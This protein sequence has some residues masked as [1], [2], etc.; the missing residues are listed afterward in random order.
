RCKNATPAQAIFSAVTGAH[1]M[2]RCTC[3]STGPGRAWCASRGSGFVELCLARSSF[4]TGAPAV[5]YRPA[6]AAVVEVAAVAA[7]AVAVA[8]AITTTRSALSSMIALAVATALALEHLVPGLDVPT[9]AVIT[10]RSTARP[11]KGFW[12]TREAVEEHFRAYLLNPSEKVLI[13]AGS[14]GTCK[15]TAA[16]HGVR[17]VRGTVYV[18]LSWE[19]KLSKQ[20]LVLVGM[21]SIERHTEISRPARQRAWCMLRPLFARGSEAKAGRSAKRRRDEPAPPAAPTP[22]EPAAP[23]SAGPLVGRPKRLKEAPPQSAPAQP[24]SARTGRRHAEPS[25]LVTAAAAAAGGNSG[26]GNEEGGS[27]AA[28][29]PPAAAVLEASFAAATAVMGAGA[30]IAGATPPLA[31]PILPPSLVAPAATLVPAAAPVA[32]APYALR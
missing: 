12:T 10:E 3:S 20:V 21:P 8:V 27:N 19:D 14:K 2:R 29:P 13:V 11:V 17:D 7:V 26:S 23:D 22:P 16:L 24:A 25:E 18:S 6:A 4:F 5:G 32:A 30:G 9:F 15:S 28:T 1:R 31:A